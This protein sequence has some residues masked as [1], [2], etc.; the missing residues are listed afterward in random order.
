MLKGHALWWVT[1]LWRISNLPENDLSRDLC[2]P[3][4]EVPLTLWRWG[5]VSS[6]TGLALVWEEPRSSLALLQAC[7]KDGGNKHVPVSKKTCACFK[8]CRYKTADCIQHNSEFK[9]IFMSLL[10]LQTP[11]GG[12]L[13]PH[14]KYFW[15][16]LKLGIFW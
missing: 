12:C 3:A 1:S 8:Y 16:T 7:F 2:S 13:R 4:G 5:N 15:T 10:I 6:S 9:A 11:F 14:I